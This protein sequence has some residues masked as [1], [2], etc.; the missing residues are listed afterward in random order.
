MFRSVFLITLIACLASFTFV[1]TNWELQKEKNGVK[2]YTA[3]KAG[4]KYKQ[5]KAIVSFKGNVSSVCDYLLN[6]K[7]FKGH[8]DRIEKIKVIKT[9]SKKAI[10]YMAVDLPWPVSNRDGIYTVSL[11]S[12]TTNEAKLT[13]AAN[14][15]MIAEVKDYVRV[16]VSNTVYTVKQK[17]EK[18]EVTMQVHTEPGGSVPAWVGNYY[19]EDSPIEIMEAIRTDLTK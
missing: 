6:P 11:I 13:I 16:K 8:S 18:V 7:N 4:S 17:G 19:V 2:V 10:Y 5:C 15:K 14:P 3:D 9:T 1:G 12:K